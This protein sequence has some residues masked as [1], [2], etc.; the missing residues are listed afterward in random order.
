MREKS[1]WLLQLAQLVMAI[2]QGNENG[3][4]VVTSLSNRRGFYA[5]RLNERGRGKS[6]CEK[7]R[8]A[9]ANCNRRDADDRRRVRSKLGQSRSPINPNYLL[10]ELNTSAQPDQPA[11]T[12]HQSHLAN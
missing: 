12:T 3:H 4:D 2:T 5:G 1:L 11:A 10:E 6:H 7:W 8:V 9:I